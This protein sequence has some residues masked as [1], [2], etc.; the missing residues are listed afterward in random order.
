MNN[1][2][3]TTT[4]DLSGIDANTTTKDVDDK[5]YTVGNGV[6]DVTFKLTNALY[7]NQKTHILYGNNDNDATPDFAI[8]LSGVSSLEA[9]DFIL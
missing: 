3:I 1:S 7:F 5:F 6:V 2:V 4:I 9:S 8:Q